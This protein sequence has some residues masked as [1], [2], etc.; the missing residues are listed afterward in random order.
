MGRG[1]ITLYN[2]FCNR[3]ISNM[4]KQFVKFKHWQTG[5]VITMQYNPMAIPVHDNSDRI[6]VWNVK[7]GKLE[8]IIRDT[9]IEF[10]EEEDVQSDSI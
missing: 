3:I 7:E 5:E 6:L 1:R 2:P 9:I 8:D 4:S 10:W